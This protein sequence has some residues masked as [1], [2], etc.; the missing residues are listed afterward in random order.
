VNCRQFGVELLGLTH[1]QRGIVTQSSVR[2]WAS[3]SR[4]RHLVC[5]DSHTARHGA[6]GALAF[7]IGTTEVGH[8][9]SDAVPAAAQAAHACRQRGTLSCARVVPPKDL[10]LAIMGGSACR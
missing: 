4:A 5:G 9:L 8:V 10:I 1:S 6:V 3:R 7:G 2:S